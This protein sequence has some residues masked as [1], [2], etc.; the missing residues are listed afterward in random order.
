VRSRSRSPRRRKQGRSPSPREVKRENTTRSNRQPTPHE[1]REKDPAP[2]AAAAPLPPPPSPAPALP[3]HDMPLVYP[4]GYP[5]TGPWR[6][7]SPLPPKQHPPTH[8]LGEKSLVVSRQQSL[9]AGRAAEHMAIVHSYV[10]VDW[11]WE[12]AWEQAQVDIPRKTG[13]LP[14]ALLQPSLRAAPKTRRG[15]AGL[16]PTSHGTHS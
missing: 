2:P 7:I 5:T 4:S 15:A 3:P 11:P 12:L 1:G 13:P 6:G 8:P 16:L 10:A 14:S 9:D